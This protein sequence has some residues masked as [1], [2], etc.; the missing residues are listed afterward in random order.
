MISGKNHQILLGSAVS[1]RWPELGKGSRYGPMVYL[2]VVAYP[3]RV[4]LDASHGGECQWE[5]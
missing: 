5:K 1:R 2:G 3:A 4:R